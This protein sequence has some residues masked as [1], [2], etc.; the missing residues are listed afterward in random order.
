MAAISYEAHI[1]HAPSAAKLETLKERALKGNLELESI[2]SAIA[3]AEKKLAE[4]KQAEAQAQ[5]RKLARELLKRADAIVEHACVLDNAN[6]IRIEASH[7]ISDELTEMRS[8]AHGI[9]AFV[10]SHEQF[11]ALGTSCRIN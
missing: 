7:A 2:A 10:P 8:L 6:R 4:A 1:G 9:A 11:T 3:V 5:A